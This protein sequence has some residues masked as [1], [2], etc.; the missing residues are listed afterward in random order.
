MYKIT[1]EC[2]NC[3]ACE[4]E[5]PNNAIYE[6][7]ENR[8]FIVPEKCTECIGKYENPQCVTVC[9]VNCIK[10]YKKKNNEK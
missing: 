6:S 2:I 1:N 5:C 4:L 7:K 10:K 8:Y 3:G 9:P